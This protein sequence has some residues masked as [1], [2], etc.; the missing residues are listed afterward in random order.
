MQE[1]Y[2][3]KKANLKKNKPGCGGT[4]MGQNYFSKGRK[5]EHI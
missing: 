4:N 3:E 1:K 5:R 2:H